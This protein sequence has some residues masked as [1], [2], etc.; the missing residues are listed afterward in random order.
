MLFMFRY[1]GWTTGIVVAKYQA[2]GNYYPTMK[3]NVQPLSTTTQTRPSPC[4]SKPT[5][6][7]TQA[8]ITK[9]TE[10]VTTKSVTT[11][12]SQPETQATTQPSCGNYKFF[13]YRVVTQ[14]MLELK[15]TNLKKRPP[16]VPTP[17][18]TQ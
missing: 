4:K 7:P 6:Q 17:T 18:N 9:P 1:E 2:P 14:N 11:T 3:D 10:E 15:N 8:P 16:H 5:A 12:I 13:G